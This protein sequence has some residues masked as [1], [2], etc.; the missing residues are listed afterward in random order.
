VNS[1]APDLVVTLGFKLRV[2]SPGRRVDLEFVE[3]VLTAPLQVQG[4]ESF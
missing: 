1:A 3:Q 2:S 4:E